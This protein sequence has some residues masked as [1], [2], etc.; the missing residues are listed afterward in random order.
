MRRVVSGIALF[1]CS[2]ALAIAGQSI[3]L[4]GSVRIANETIPTQP[5]SAVC[6]TEFSFHDW[7]DSPPPNAHPWDAPACGFEIT[8]YNFGNGDIRLQVYATQDV[9]T[10][11]CMIPLGVNADGSS[12]L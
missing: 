2:G 10:A 8:L 12:V 3:R 4:P 9:T 6:R 5:S 7:N 11:V 1:V